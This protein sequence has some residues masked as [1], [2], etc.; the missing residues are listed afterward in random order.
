M[1]LSA[2]VEK[3]KQPQDADLEETLGPAYVHWNVL[4]NLIASR[5]GPVS[6]EWGFAT[7]WGLRVKTVKRTILYLTPCEGYFLASFALGEKA[8]NAAH[9][10]A[11]PA[12]VLRVIDSAKKY[13]EGRGVRLKVRS[14][15]DV[16]N[17]EK[18]ATIK[19]AT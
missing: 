2:F 13:A 15:K 8:V 7:G 4:K 18:V 9:Q 19:M 1:A 14:S 6:F 17:V 5:F 12:A 11:L 16:R 3:S 10:N